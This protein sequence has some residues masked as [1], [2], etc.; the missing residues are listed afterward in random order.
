M[1]NP[2]KSI[3]AV[4]ITMIAPSSFFR[5][6]SFSEALTNYIV[7]DHR[8]ASYARLVKRTGNDMPENIRR[9]AQAVVRIYAHAAHAAKQAVHAF[10][11]A[12]KRSS[13]YEWRQTMAIANIIYR[14]WD[15]GIGAFTWGN[16]VYKV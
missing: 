16:T 3:D 15:P 12:R 2:Q 10:Y 9:E 14:H 6:K 11:R 7:M 8:A 13:S 5:V 4:G 1:Y